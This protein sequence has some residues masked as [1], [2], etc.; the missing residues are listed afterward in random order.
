M[1]V[2]N[3]TG[4]NLLWAKLKEKGAIVSYEGGS[5]LV[6]KLMTEIGRPEVYRGYDI[7][8]VAPIDGVT[9][10]EWDITEMALP[11]TISRRE[12]RMNSGPA[13]ITKM[14]E[15]KM[16]QA[17][18]GF[19]Q[20]WMQYFMQGNKS[21]NSGST[22]DTPVVNQSNSA[23]GFD[24]I[25]KLIAKDPTVSAVVGNI[26]QSTATYWRNKTKDFGGIAVTPTLFLNAM[27]DL[28]SLCAENNAGAPDVILTDR[29]TYNLWRS[30]YYAAYRNTTSSAD[31]PFDN[32]KFNGAVVTW[33]SNVPDVQNGTLSTATKGT[34]YMLNTDYLSI[35]VDKESE[36]S[37]TK[38]KEPA[39]Q[40]A[41]V[42]HLLWMGGITTS[43]RRAHGVC[44]NIPRTLA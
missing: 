28:Y 38:F 4:R 19:N 18:L 16:K 36:F 7:L 20:Y 40:T 39:N 5:Y 21:I 30:A 15:T 11:I 44:Y 31:Y 9:Q 42:A 13:A 10:A 1:I 43:N 32:F 26:N 27:D 35:Q 6:E 23:V 2:D 29:L 33:D 14:L 17:T 8:P 12:E 25:A 3:V 24:P 22:I 34:V 41:K 37:M